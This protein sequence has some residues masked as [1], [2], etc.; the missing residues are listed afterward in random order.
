M[1]TE[2]ACIK[3]RHLRWAVMPYGQSLLYVSLIQNG[4]LEHVPDCMT[5]VLVAGQRLNTFANDS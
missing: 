1:Y 4:R 2:Y 3:L 5:S